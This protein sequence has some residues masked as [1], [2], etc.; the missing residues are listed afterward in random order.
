M[1][2]MDNVDLTGGRDVRDESFEEDKV[3]DR[4]VAVGA[5][6]LRVYVEELGPAGLMMV[7]KRIFC[8]MRAEEARAAREP[9]SEDERFCGSCFR[10]LMPGRDDLAI[11]IQDRILE[12]YKKSRGC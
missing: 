1:S 12:S 11:E 3:T 4:M 6:H 5:L 8:A 10:P 7:A 2:Q 9:L